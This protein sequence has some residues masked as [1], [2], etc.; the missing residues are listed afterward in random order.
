MKNYGFT[1]IELLVVV[2]IIGILAS[3]GV[4][5]YNGYTT[6]AKKNSLISRQNIA[7]K[8]LT[9]EFEKCNIGEKLYLNGSTNFDQCTRVLNPGKSTTRNLAKVTVN[10][11]NN[12]MGWKNTVDNT[13]PGSTQG[14]LKNCELGSICIDGYVSDRILV[15]A[16]YND[17]PND[18]VS[19]LIML[20]Y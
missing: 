8:F 5:A 13:K 2:A 19:N 12:I 14:N 4:V 6:N 11:F 7:L 18:F 17:N 3:I 16:N 20:N 15:I 10:H 9:A 1:L